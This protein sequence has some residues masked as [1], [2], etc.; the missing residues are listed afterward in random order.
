[1]A[2]IDLPR[3]VSFLEAHAPADGVPAPMAVFDCDGTLIQGDIG[4]AMFYRQI[5]RWWFK[6]SPAALWSDHPQRTALDETFRAVSA[7]SPRERSMAPEFEQCASLMI[8]WYFDQIRDGKVVKAC[9]DIVR[10]L[11]GF[12]LEEVR[13][14][15]SETFADELAAPLSERRLGGRRL[16]RG[17]RYLAETVEILNALKSRGFDIWAVSGSCVY[18]IEPVFREM[19]VP[20]NRL[21]GIEMELRDGLLSAI[22]VEPIPIREGKIGAMQ[23]R[24][25]NVPVFSAS[26][27]RND[28]PLLLYS[29]DLKVRV[30]SRRR[31]TGEF[32]DAVG[33]PMDA[34][35]INIETPTI[36][37]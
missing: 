36:L 4:E 29:S 30:N 31:D 34:S 6:N 17:I 26:D 7:L 32:F 18:S 27:S 11:S 35:W 12:T 28:I 33:A 10:L 23:R 20:S 2:I 1:M 13:T 15:A 5:E 19:G 25:K 37:S 9:T 8:S 21:I 3:F 16:P 22:E 14:F 24:T